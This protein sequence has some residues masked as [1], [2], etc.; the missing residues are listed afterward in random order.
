[1]QLINQTHPYLRILCPDGDYEVFQGGLLEI[2]PTLTVEGPDPSI[3]GDDSETHEVPNP[4]Y[5][6]VMAE[7]QRNPLI[8]IIQNAT[9]CPHCGELFAGKLAK[10]ELGKHLKANHF[11]VWI[12]KHDEKAAEERSIL[13]KSQAIF[14]CDVCVPLQQFPSAEE[15]GLHTK[16]V[17]EQA[18]PMDADGN[19]I[20]PRD[21]RG[22]S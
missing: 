1:M 17:H 19:E 22:L 12:A 9:T 16:L 11:E 2:H 8:A 7:A 6:A 18:P 14:P 10:A 13:V 5:D 21:D 4:H 3:E 15:L 20:G